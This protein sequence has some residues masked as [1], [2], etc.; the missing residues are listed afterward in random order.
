MHRK[1]VKATSFDR[2]IDLRTKR[3]EQSIHGGVISAMVVFFL[4]LSRTTI[5]RAVKWRSLPNECKKSELLTGISW[6]LLSCRG[7]T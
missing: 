2:R 6:E 4:F 3:E 5:G 1:Q 7:L